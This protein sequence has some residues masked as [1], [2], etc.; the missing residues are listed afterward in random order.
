MVI[1]Q[2]ILHWTL[3]Y[4]HL[5][6]GYVVTLA[7]WATYKCHGSSPSCHQFLLSCDARTANSVV[8]PVH[9]T[10]LNREELV[11]VAMTLRTE[12][13]DLASDS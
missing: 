2:I 8:T 12:I 3:Y 13:I 4:L 10:S 9:K 5:I 11:Y 6:N 7:A 1:V